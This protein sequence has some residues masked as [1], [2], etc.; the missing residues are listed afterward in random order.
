MYVYFIVH[1]LPLDFRVPA[2]RFC[3]SPRN[4]VMAHSEDLSKMIMREPEVWRRPRRRS[5]PGAA[6]LA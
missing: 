1:K 6:I 3:R 4:G 2:H 5:L